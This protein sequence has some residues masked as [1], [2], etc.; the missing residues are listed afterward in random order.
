MREI[1]IKNVIQKDKDYYFFTDKLNNL[2]YKVIDKKN[3]KPEVLHKE[4]MS[5][6]V[7]EFEVFLES[8]D[9]IYVLFK[10]NEEL[11]CAF[12]NE[13]EINVGS[14]YCSENGGFDISET[15]MF[16]LNN[17]INVVAVL[18]SQEDI[19]K[20]IVM[21]Y[22]YREGKVE[23]NIICKVFNNKKTNYHLMLEK[24]NATVFYSFVEDSKEI[25]S[26]R[27]FKDNT[28]GDSKKLISV[29]GS[30]KEMD[31]VKYYD[32]ICLGIIYSNYSINILKILVIKNKTLE[33]LEEKTYYDTEKLDNIYFLKSNN[34]FYLTWNKNN[35]NI[36]TSCIENNKP[37]YTYIIDEFNGQIAIC[38]VNEQKQNGVVDRYKA[39]LNKVNDKVGFIDIHELLIL[40]GINRQDI[41]D[42]SSNV[43]NILG[44]ERRRER[45][46][47]SKL[48][49]NLQNL[50]KELE[51]KQEELKNIVNKSEEN[52]SE[53]LKKAYEQNVSKLVKEKE[54]LC[55]EK[56][57]LIEDNQHLKKEMIKL[58][59]DS[60]QNIS[61]LEIQ[62]S[63]VSREYAEMSN[64]MRNF[65]EENIDNEKNLK[66]YKEIVS[67]LNL[68]IE[69]LTNKNHI[70]EEK[71]KEDKVLIDKLRESEKFKNSFENN[72]CELQKKVLD[73][74]KELNAT[75]ELNSIRMREYKEKI[76]EQKNLLREEQLK[77]RSVFERIFNK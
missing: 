70:L 12:F 15:K 6:N 46:V 22:V 64:S 51:R 4:I 71:A 53:T 16:I 8:S 50:Q 32:N 13:G 31:V 5:P 44:V 26:Y 14:L 77:S 1:T 54:K 18:K 35:K 19:N 76:E 40:N 10:K 62:L 61:D 74:K 30:I 73:L 52:S 17:S 38:N 21:H 2:Y 63:N 20:D 68:N 47:I 33:V 56:K 48:K 9:K 55:K 27:N 3:N 58:K 24:D 72:I 39:L 66:K 7:V 65:T 25:I 43:F 23:S 28:W 69:Q 75:I 67:S 42:Y 34:K 29:S 45:D 49:F 60:D 57:Q 41:F 36:V 11:E 59:H 37:I